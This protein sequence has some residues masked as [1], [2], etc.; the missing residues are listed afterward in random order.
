MSQ[1]PPSSGSSANQIRSGPEIVADFVSALKNDPKLDKST[2]EAIESLFQDKRLT[3]TNLLK[4]LEEARG[5][6]SI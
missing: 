2:V 4:M 6:T 1:E 3:P 5:K